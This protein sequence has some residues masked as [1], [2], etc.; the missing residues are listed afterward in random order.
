MSKRVNKASKQEV[1]KVAPKKRIN[2][3]LLFVL[4]KVVVLGGTFLYIVLKERE[5]SP[6]AGIRNTVYQLGMGAVD[7]INAELMLRDAKENNEE[8]TLNGNDPNYIALVDFSEYSNSVTSMT[9]AERA[10]KVKESEAIFLDTIGISLTAQQAEASMYMMDWWY[11]EDPSMLLD[12]GDFDQLPL[13]I[14][15]YERMWNAGAAAA[16]SGDIEKMRTFL[17]VEALALSE[18]LSEYEEFMTNLTNFINVISQES[19]TTDDLTYDDIMTNMDELG[20]D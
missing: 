14:D 9:E 4:L 2:E 5:P 10:K 15:I 1:N 3:A 18:E 20:I 6:I 7:A 13:I 16:A 8:S 12:L 11:K 19:L 17:D